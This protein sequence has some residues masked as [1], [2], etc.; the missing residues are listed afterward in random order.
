[1]RKNITLTL[2]FFGVLL[3]VACSSIKSTNNTQ[4]NVNDNSNEMELSDAEVNPEFALETYLRRTAGVVVNGSGVNATVQ[5]RG[6]NSFTGNTQPLF[7]INGT[8]VGSN[9]NN[10]ASL[11]RGMKI[12]SVEVL[13]GSDASFYGVRGSGGVIVIRAE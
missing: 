7:V 11:L 13:K 9:Y 10:A 5:V 2:L 8:D 12:K 3:M 6:I 4:T 1:M